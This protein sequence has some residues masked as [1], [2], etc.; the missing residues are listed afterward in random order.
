MR[1][2]FID[3]QNHSSLR[4]IKERFDIYIHAPNN[5]LRYCYLITLKYLLSV[6]EKEKYFIHTNLSNGKVEEI[7]P[8]SLA[9]NRV[10]RNGSLFSRTMRNKNL[11][12]LRDINRICF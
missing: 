12:S 9:L 6:R 10:S 3:T 7:G 5:P 4:N 11:T 8:L 1:H 2:S